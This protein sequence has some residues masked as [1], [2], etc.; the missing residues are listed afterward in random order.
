MQPF[1]V[2]E[3]LGRGV[4]MVRE[5]ATEDGVEVA[6]SQSRCRRRRGRRRRIKQ[7]IFNLLSNAVDSRPPA[8]RST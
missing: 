8:G 4:V 7:V 5:R 1:S 6:L 3:V 2:R